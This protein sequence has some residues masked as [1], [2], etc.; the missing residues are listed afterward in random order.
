MLDESN[1]M[2]QMLTELGRVIM[3]HFS[4]S[5]AFWAISDRSDTDMMGQFEQFV[6][7]TWDGNTYDKLR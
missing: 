4:H 3:E 5:P 2:K 1:N 7:I 6:R